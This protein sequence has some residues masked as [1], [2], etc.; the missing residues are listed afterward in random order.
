[1]FHLV[2]KNQVRSLTLLPNLT[3]LKANL[4]VHSDNTPEV[5]MGARGSVGYRCLLKNLKNSYLDVPMIF[6]RTSPSLFKATI[7][8]IRV[9]PKR[10]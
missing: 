8:G 7:V 4:F 2:L 3:I 10:F 1:M 6:S 9:T 5:Q